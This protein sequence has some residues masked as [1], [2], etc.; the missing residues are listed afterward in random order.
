M[1]ERF[2]DE[3]IV[4]W[5]KCHKC[6]FQQVFCMKKHEER[7]YNLKNDRWVCPIKYWKATLSAHGPMF[8]NFVRR[9]PQDTFAMIND[10]EKQ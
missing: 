5:S 4:S 7:E 8:D 3:K 6:N 1:V 2:T 9:T 10:N